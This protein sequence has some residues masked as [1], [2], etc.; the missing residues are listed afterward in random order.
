MRCRNPASDPRRCKEAFLQ[1]LHNGQGERV[2][3]GWRV[4]WHACQNRYS[5]SADVW[6]FGIVLLELAR[7]KAPLSH[8]PFTKIILDTVHG[9]A[10]SLEGGGSDRRFSK[11]A[12]PIPESLSV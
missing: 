2:C 7:G 1:A 6:S 11:V 9:P 8:C 10:P 3:E 4:A 12:T 5:Q